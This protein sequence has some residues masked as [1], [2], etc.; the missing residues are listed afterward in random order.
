MKE[1]STILNTSL[2]ALFEGVPD[3]V[4]SYRPIGV[5][6][7]YESV[8]DVSCHISFFFLFCK[9]AGVALLNV[10]RDDVLDLWQN[11]LRLPLPDGVPA[12]EIA[13]ELTNM[14][15]GNATALLYERGHKT[16]IAVPHIIDCGKQIKLSTQKRDDFHYF[17]FF[18][19][20]L[21]FN[22]VHCFYDVIE[23]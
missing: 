21:R 1:Y 8:Y 15:V 6:K 3:R 13:S 11:V 18:D 16:Q 9:R 12:G 7:F 4:V 22:W 10:N 23:F 5:E 20:K 2:S 14:I 19:D 17:E